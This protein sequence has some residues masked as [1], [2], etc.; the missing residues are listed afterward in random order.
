MNGYVSCMG[1]CVGCR[2]MITFNPNKV[3]SVR[4]KDGHL[5]PDGKREPLCRACAETINQNRINEGKEPCVIAD[6]AYDPLPENEL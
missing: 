3:P 4:V 1:V 2:T 5:H 6:D